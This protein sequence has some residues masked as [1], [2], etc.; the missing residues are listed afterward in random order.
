MSKG[1]KATNPHLVQVE[2]ANEQ[3]VLPEGYERD[4]YLRVSWLT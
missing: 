2:E 3:E 1:R 4:L